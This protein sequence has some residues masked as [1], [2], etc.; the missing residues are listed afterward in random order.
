LIV[1]AANSLL[2]IGSLAKLNERKAAQ[3]TGVAVRGQRDIRQWTDCGEVF[4]Q[5]SLGYVIR[6]VT[7]KKAYTHQV[8]LQC[9]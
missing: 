5:V 4:T 3:P 9:V 6:Q 1:E 2:S 8:F 7:N